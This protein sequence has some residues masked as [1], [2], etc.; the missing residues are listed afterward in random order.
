MKIY[1]KTGDKGETSLVGGE[2]TPKNSPLIEA[3]GTIDELNAS[4]GLILAEIACPE[5][6]KIQQELFTIGGL[7]ATP[8][9]DWVKYWKDVDIQ[10]LINELEKEI[11]TKSE[12]LPPMKS[13]IL[14]GGSRAIAQIHFSR[15]ICRR[16]ERN[17]VNI[18]NENKHY[19]LLLQ[20]V[21]RLSDFLFI[22]AR[23]YHKIQNVDEI[24]WKSIK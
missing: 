11:D 9:N 6:E 12:G 13:F 5:L 4:I 8:V 2:R 17:I 24:I 19:L 3:Y 1:T 23:Y 16:A 14:P 18:T 20:Y 7:L 10:Q 21:N 15:T 22:L